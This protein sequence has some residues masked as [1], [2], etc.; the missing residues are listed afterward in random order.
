MNKF[1]LLIALIFLAFNI[2]CKNSTS[3]ENTEPTASFAINPTSGT[4]ETTFTFDASGCTDI[5]DEISELQV[6]WDFNDN[7]IWN[8]DYSTT[9]TATHKYTTPG[10]YTVKLEVKDSEGLTNFTTLEVAVAY[11]SIQ[12]GDQVWMAD[13]LKV[14]HYRNGEVI[15][16]VTD[17]T[18]WLNLSAGAYCNYD[19]DVDYVP[20]YGRMYNWY[21]VDDSR[22]LAPAGWHIPSDEEWK[23]LEMYLGMSQSEINQ[24]HVWRGTGEVG[25]KLKEAG[26]THWIGLN[27]GATNS[28]GFT[29]LPGGYR[30]Y[31]SGTFNDMGYTTF[32]W[33]STAEGPYAWGR[34]LRAGNSD[35]DR[36]HYSRLNGLS[37]RCIKD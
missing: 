4:A 21:A 28:T 37:V 18:E 31:I 34:G 9:K 32:F 16:N 6:R 23:E 11:N 17:K 33:S 22:N 27:T 10:T 8:A 5:E 7:G 15:Q 12:I 1:L 30:H 35:V 24:F 13:N 19:N 26:T 29:A 14:T 20:T 3:S 36:W 2:T 25:G